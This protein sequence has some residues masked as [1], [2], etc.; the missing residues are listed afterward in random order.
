MKQ[1][2][3]DSGKAARP[4]AKKK[5]VAPNPWESLAPDGKGLSV[6]DFLTTTVV[7]LG[8]ELKRKVTQPYVERH[9]LTQ[10]QWRILSVIAEHPQ[11]RLSDLVMQAAVDKALVSRVLRQL[12]ALGLV[13]LDSVP[14]APRKGLQC[15]LSP[16]GRKL[17]GK[18]V[19]HARQAQADMILALTPEERRMAYDVLR[20]LYRLCK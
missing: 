20:K 2:S 18:A 4:A 7:R 14:N 6:D 3:T 8:I 19:A 13:Q 11:M 15:R 9:G 5:G 10:S 1:S 16:S 12:E 17:Y